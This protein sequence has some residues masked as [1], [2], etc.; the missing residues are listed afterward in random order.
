MIGRWP[1]HA[2]TRRA[3]VIRLL[4]IGQ[5]AKHH[6]PHRL[7]ES[8]ETPA[9][10]TS[11]SS[12]PD[13]RRPFCASCLRVNTDGTTTLA[14]SFTYDSWGKPTTATHNGIGD[15]GFRY[16][17]VG[18]FDVQWDNAFGLGLHYMHARHYAPDLGLFIQ[19]DPAGLEINH[20]SYSSNSP[21]TYIDPT[22]EL[23]FFPL[24]LIAARAIAVVAPAVLA[25]AQKWGPKIQ[26]TTQQIADRLQLSFNKH[27]WPWNTPQT[28]A[29]ISNAAGSTSR[30][31]PNMTQ[32]RAES[33]INAARFSRLISIPGRTNLWSRCTGWVW[34]GTCY[35]G[36]WQYN[37]TTTY[38]FPFRIGWDAVGKTWT[39][40]V[41]YVWTS[42]SMAVYPG[43]PTAWWNYVW[44]R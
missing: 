42:G 2:R 26:K 41:T 24:A 29:A 11:P 22:G 20:Y 40:T 28:T 9:K 14:N 15:L 1:R 17:Y 23:A 27:L 12:R 38:T 31:L 44:G 21:V 34:A 25:A 4:V 37:F 36:A 30:F 7:R 18:Q 19:P 13:R 3:R 33:I 5:R 43:R 6:A 32:T 35:G 16:L 10:T 39:N 8:D